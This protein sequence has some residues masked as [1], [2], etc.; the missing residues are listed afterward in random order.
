[1]LSGRRRPPVDP[2]WKTISRLETALSRGPCGL[3]TCVT[4]TFFSSVS[5]PSQH[6]RAGWAAL[7]LLK[8]I[9][10]TSSAL[11]FH[12]CVWLPPILPRD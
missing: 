1:M 5:P 9:S 11:F 12:P 3:L 2:R 4:L 7:P 10:S 8:N 6:E